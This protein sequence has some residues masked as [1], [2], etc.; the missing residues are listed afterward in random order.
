[1][2]ITKIPLTARLQFHYGDNNPV[3]RFTGI[4]PAVTPH[5]LNMIKTQL[6]VLQTIEADHAFI[7]IEAELSAD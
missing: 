5:G 2:A 3:L 4:N 7:T 1:M 6:D